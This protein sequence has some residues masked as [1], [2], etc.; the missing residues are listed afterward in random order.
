MSFVIETGYDGGKDL[1]VTGEWTSEAQQALEAGLADRLV[2]NYARGF[3]P[4]PLDFLR[5]LPLRKLVLLDRSVTDLH[6]IYSLAPTLTELRVQSDQKA[7]IEL[8]RLP[9]LRT[10][11]ASWPQIQGSIAYA[12]QLEDL[13]VPSY[14]EPDLSALTVLPALASLVMKQR[15]RLCSLA[16]L[17]ALPRLRHLG[18]HMARELDDVSALSLTT[19]R[20]ETLQITASK[21]LTEVS[22][23]AS[24]TAL[25]FLELS[26]GGELPSALPFAG[27]RKLK[28]LY[29][30]GSTKISDGDL[31]PILE[32]PELR[33]FRIMN[34]RHYTPSNDEVQAAIQRRLSR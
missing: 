17:E 6:A 2:L 10:L 5:G 9:M 31:N 21:G 32:L 23:I 26:E 1:V 18:V 4:Q 24:A 27:L 22:P 7:T 8:E 25:Q 30:F 33:D 3:W 19:S 29:L 13:S 12:P 20:L 34:R 11:A 14:A 28:R 15:P 16:G